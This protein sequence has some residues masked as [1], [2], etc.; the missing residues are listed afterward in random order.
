MNWLPLLSVAIG[1]FAMMTLAWARQVRTLN[2]SYVDVLWAAGLG[3]AAIWYAITASGAPV[4]RTAVAVLGALWGLRLAAHLHVRVHG[5]AEDGRYA[6]LREHWQG[7][8]GKF[9]GF[10]M[11]QALLV[12]MF[13]LPFL[14]AANNPLTGLTPWTIAAIMVF[15]VA[16]GGESVADAQLARWRRDAAN[17]GRTCRAGLWRYSR[18]PNYFFEWLHW[19]TYPLLAVGAP[20]WWLT[21]LGPVLMGLSLAWLTGI[22]YT[23]AQALR[24]RGDDYRAYQRETSA[25]FPWFPRN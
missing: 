3:V 23:E 6:F 5:H 24:S 12:V 17:R 4:P 9:F 13:S 7:H 15:A 22:P 10:F 8:Q 1:A 16:L 11:A 20:G 18:H 25:F 21:L 19:F 14:V 2:A